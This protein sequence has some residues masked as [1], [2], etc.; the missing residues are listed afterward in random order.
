MIKEAWLSK[1]VSGDIVECLACSHKCKLPLDGKGICGIRKNIEGELQLLTYGKATAFNIDPIEKKP[2]YHFFP[3]TEVF[4]FGTVGCNFACTFC[5]N[6]DLSQFHKTHSDEEIIE[7]GTGLMPDVIVSYCLEN[8]IPTIA[9]TYNEPG[10]FFEY[11]YDTAKLAK[12]HN[13][14]VVY[15]S[16]GFESTE[17]LKKILPYLDAINIDLK[18]ISNDFYKRMCK[19]RIGP[20]KKNIELMYK[21]NVWLEVTTLVITDENDSEDE[22]QSISEFIARISKDIPWHI[23]AY[24]PSYLCKNPSTSVETLKKAYKIGKKAGLNY[25]YLGNVSIFDSESTYCSKCK[26]ILIKRDEYLLINK[27]KSNECYKCKTKIVGRF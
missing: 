13:L 20:V 12:K 2:L 17:S 5:Q 10:I 22:F 4:S 18:S 19:A 26:S 3:G 9:F 6:S 15:V 8:E 24:H 27:V 21:K 14:K 1:K 11:A 23:S 25:V 16:N 7:S